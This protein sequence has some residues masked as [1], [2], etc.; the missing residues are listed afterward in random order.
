QSVKNF[1]AIHNGSSEKFNR[2]IGGINKK[3][4][5][6]LTKSPAKQKRYDNEVLKLVQDS[7]RESANSLVNKANTMHL[8]VE[9]RND[10][11]DFAIKAREGPGTPLPQRVKHAAT[12]STGDTIEF[13]GK[14]KRDATGHI[15]GFDFDNFDQKSMAQTIALGTDFLMHYGVKGMHWGV[16][17]EQAITTQTHIDTGLLRRKTQIQAKGGQSH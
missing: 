4:P 1:V 10:G 3:Y 2:E 15:V 5:G 14:I 13:T 6:D 11:M 16:R 7:Y 8:D 9:F 17:R 12:D